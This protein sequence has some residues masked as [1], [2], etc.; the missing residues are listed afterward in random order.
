[1]LEKLKFNVGRSQSVQEQTGALHLLVTRAQDER[2]ALQSA[3]RSPGASRTHR[4]LAGPAG[5]GRHREGHVARQPPRRTDRRASSALE[6]RASAI[7]AL[8]A[9]IQALTDAAASAERKVQDALGP[10]SDLQKHRLLMEQVS[11][12]GDAAPGLHPEHRAPPAHARHA[13]GPGVAE[14]QDARAPAADRRA[15]RGAVQPRVGDGV[16]DGH[17]D[18]DRRRRPGAPVVR[19]ADHRA[20]RTPRHGSRGEAGDRVGRRVRKPS[21]TSTTFTGQRQADHGRPDR[22]RPRRS[23]RAAPSS[24]R[25]KRAPARLQESLTRAE[26]RMTALAALDKQISTVNRQVDSVSRRFDTLA[27]QAETLGRKQEGLRRPARAARA[28]ERPGEADRAAARDAAAEP[29]HHQRAAARAEGAQPRPTP[30]SRSSA[31]G[32]RPSGA[33]SKRSANGCRRCRDGRSRSTRR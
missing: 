9:R 16:V 13:V 33:R 5:A 24:T 7:D 14:G 18:Q 4:G 6:S 25:S 3:S 30:R 12:A 22:P 11:A 27:S 15:R 32:C 26:S 19:R 23:K 28:D 29:A 8:D 1:M 21:A 10:S 2:T 17:A 20:D 31:T